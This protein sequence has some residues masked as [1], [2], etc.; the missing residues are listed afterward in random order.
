MANNVIVYAQAGSLTAVQPGVSISG[1]AGGF[2]T[3]TCRYLQPGSASSIS[4]AYPPGGATGCPVAV[5]TGGK[6]LLM[7]VSDGEDLPGGYYI[8]TLTWRGLLNGSKG[9]QSSASYSVRE[10]TYSALAG[11]P[12]AP[13]TVKARVLDVAPGYSVRLITTTSPVPPKPVQGT[14]AY[15]IPAGAP[16]INGQD[17]IDVFNSSKTYVYPFGW[18]PY[19]WSYEEPLPGIYFL[20]ADY[21]YEFPIQFG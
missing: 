12:G 9:G 18:I 5:A 10:T 19:N 3:V 2:D 14:G 1:D 7:G 4:T 15:P 16:T 21:K 20:T 6:M 8:F 13:G 17:Q 11:V